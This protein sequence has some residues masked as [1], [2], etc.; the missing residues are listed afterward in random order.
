MPGEDFGVWFDRYRDYVKHEDGLIN[1][2]ITWLVAMQSI[3][4]GTFSFACQKIYELHSPPKGTIG[5]EGPDVATLVY[6]ALL[7]GLGV[8]G[9]LFASISRQSI[10]A[11]DRAISSLRAKWEMDFK[12]RPGFVGFPNLTGGNDNSV[13]PK[14]F[15]STLYLP[16]FFMWLWGLV[17]LSIVVVLCMNWSRVLNVVYLCFPG[18]SFAWQW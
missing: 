14:G 5:P 8:I 17:D 13:V 12:G 7:L 15:G 10:V 6:L 1:N 11:A 3:L 4:V 9:Y 16:I 18:I 2:R